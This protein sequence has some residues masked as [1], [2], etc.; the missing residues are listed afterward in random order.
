MQGQ[1]G[2]SCL[3][4][5]QNKQKKDEKELQHVPEVH[6]Y[7]L[8]IVSLSFWLTDKHINNFP[9]NVFFFNVPFVYYKMVLYA[10]R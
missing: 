3:K 7:F 5:I 1:R 9:Q 8:I 6:L 2:L 10:N 4:K